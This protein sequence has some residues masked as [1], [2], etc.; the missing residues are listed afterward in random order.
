MGI[1]RLDPRR[2]PSRLAAGPVFGECLH[3]QRAKRQSATQWV[4]R[5]P[6]ESLPES[7]NRRTLAPA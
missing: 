4:D 6:D 5:D 2:T 7:G 3:H 1:T